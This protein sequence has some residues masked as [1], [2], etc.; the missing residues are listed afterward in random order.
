[1][2]AVTISD[3]EAQYSGF[4]RII[5]VQ[6]FVTASVVLLTS[7]LISTVN[8]A[9]KTMPQPPFA[10]STCAGDCARAGAIFNRKPVNTEFLELML[11]FS[12]IMGWE[13][14]DSTVAFNY[15]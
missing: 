7:S 11:I 13:A 10:Q 4:I 1:M 8:H 2:P 12:M 3:W 6:R 15:C 5:E 9:Y 14:N